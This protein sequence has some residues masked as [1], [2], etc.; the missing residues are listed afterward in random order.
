MLAIFDRRKSRKFL[1]G[2][3][4]QNVGVSNQCLKLAE[5]GYNTPRISIESQHLID[6]AKK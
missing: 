5:S 3:C 2:D 4:Q 1:G 6:S